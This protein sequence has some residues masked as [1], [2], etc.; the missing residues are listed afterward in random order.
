MIKLTIKAVD[1]YTDT[2]HKMSE[3]IHEDG[4]AAQLEVFYEFL[5]GQGYLITYRSFLLQFG[6]YVEDYG[7]VI[8]EGYDDAEDNLEGRY[9]KS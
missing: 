9:T 3:T 8:S 1:N 6:G 4:W 2:E 7:K 5:R